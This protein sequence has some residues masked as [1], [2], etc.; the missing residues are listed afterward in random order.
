MSKNFKHAAAAAFVLVFIFLDASGLQALSIGDQTPLP[1]EI[2]DR[3]QTKTG[4]LKYTITK[5]EIVAS[6]T[7][8]KKNLRRVSFEFSSQKVPFE[9]KQGEETVWEM[10]DLWHKGVIFVPVGFVDLNHPKRKGEVVIVGSVGGPFKQAFLNN[11]GDP[12]AAQTGYPTMILP[13]PGELE[14]MPGREY[15][16]DKLRCNRHIGERLNLSSCHRCHRE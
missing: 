12:I 15:S 3:F 4:P 8:P 11:Y 14:D 2:W 16:R 6:E 9:R 5:D 10:K 7:D 1:R 13:N